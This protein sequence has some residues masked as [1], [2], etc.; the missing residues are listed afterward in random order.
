MYLSRLKHA[1][2]SIAALIMTAV[3]IGAYLWLDPAPVKAGSPND[4]NYTCSRTCGELGY[5]C[6]VCD[7][8]GSCSCK[9]SCTL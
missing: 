9:A 7:G 5:P 4:C 3:A 2:T 8:S 1:A 6:Y